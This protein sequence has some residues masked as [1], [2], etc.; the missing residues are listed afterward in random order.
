[1]QHIL[2][3]MF[4]DDCISQ[5]DDKYKE[6]IKDELDKI[7]LYANILEIPS[8]YK[9]FVSKENKDYGLY[10]KLN[11]KKQIE[12]IDLLKKE[13]IENNYCV[14]ILLILYGYIAHIFFNYYLKDYVKG[15]IVC[16][17]I[18][19]NRKNIIKV[20]NNIAVKFYE[21]KFNKKID[22]KI[23]MY[24]DCP[25]KID[26]ANN[27][28]EYIKSN[29]GPILVD[30]ITEEY[31]SLTVKINADKTL[32]GYNTDIY[33]FKTAIPSDISLQGKVASI[34]G[35]GGASRAAVVGLSEKGVRQI[36]FYTRN[37][38]NSRQTLDY[39]RA[40][41]PDVEFNSVLFEDIDTVLSMNNDFF[42]LPFC[43]KFNR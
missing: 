25:I 18:K 9:L 13:I 8:Y 36:D 15:L 3:T 38:I 42:R 30:F 35:T 23:K 11:S 2:Y 41:F 6:L 12:T 24:E 27:L 17:H 29:V 5:L 16:H 20:T 1:M 32:F 39:V 33:G 34:L 22:R 37:I 40:K 19:Y 21:E 31:L 10:K 7:Y 26:K 28:I 14:E 43:P 4:L